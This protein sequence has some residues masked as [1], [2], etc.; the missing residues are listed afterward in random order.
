M[1]TT[2][3]SLRDTGLKEKKKRKGKKLFYFKYFGSIN[4]CLTKMRLTACWWS[5]TLKELFISHA[6]LLKKKIS[7]SWKVRMYLLQMSVLWK[8]TALL[9]PNAAAS[10]YGA[11]PEHRGGTVLKFQN[12]AGWCVSTALQ[13]CDFSL[14]VAGSRPSLGSTSF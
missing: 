3:S 8:I 11:G 14:G 6:I 10:H 7:G 12:W 2:E 1:L 13:C 9:V 4:C 5:A